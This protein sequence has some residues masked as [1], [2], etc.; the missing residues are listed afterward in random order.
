M[1]DFEQAW[2]VMCRDSGTLDGDQ[3]DV[4]DAIR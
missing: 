3:L 2:A 4:V 1:G